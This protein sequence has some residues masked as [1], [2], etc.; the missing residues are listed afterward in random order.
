MEIDI[1][2]SPKQAQ[3]FHDRINK[4]G[5]D[6]RAIDEALAR[7]HSENAEA[8]VQVDPD[9]IRTLILKYSGGFGTLNDTVKQYLR[10]WFVSQGGVKVVA[11]AG[12]R[13]HSASDGQPHNPDSGIRHAAAVH[14][15]SAP[16]VS[17]AETSFYA[18]NPE[19]VEPTATEIATT[20]S[21]SGVEQVRPAEFGFD[22]GYSGSPSTNQGTDGLSPPRP[23]Y[24]GFGFGANELEI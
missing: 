8:S 12:R 22:T 19:Q 23:Y 10:K 24:G 20:D 21:G 16:V 13:V 7:V 14:P 5:T 2:L 15:G 3:S 9:A 1:I 11:R 18:G 4:D 6:A 17:I